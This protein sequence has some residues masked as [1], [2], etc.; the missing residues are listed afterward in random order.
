[1]RPL[2][3]EVQGFT[4]FRDRQE[5]DL[6][7][8]GLFVIT[9]PT[10]SGKTS[11]LDAMIFALYGRVP[12]AGRH[13]M[14]DL[15][16]HGIA[17]ARVKLEFSVDDD[18]YRV[19]RRLSRSQAQ[20]A[21][22]ERVEGDQWRS[23]VDGSGVKV[24]DTRIV[25]L[26]R[27]PYDAFTRAVVLPQ[28]EFHQFL[29]GDRD[30]RRKILTRLLGLDHYEEMGRRARTRAKDLETK[31]E[32]TD[33]VLAE[34]Y[35]DV[36]EEAKGQLEVRAAE[37][38]RRATELT[39]ALKRAEGIEAEQGTLTSTVDKLGERS[40]QIDEITAKLSDEQAGYGEAQRRHEQLAKAQHEA[41]EAL[42]KC[43]DDVVAAETRLTEG[44]KKHGTLEK[45]TRLESTVET[46][47]DAERERS[48]R[49]VMLDTLRREQRDAANAAAIAK[50]EETRTAE[51]VSEAEKRETTCRDE[52]EGRKAETGLLIAGLREAESAFQEHG[53]AATNA[54]KAAKSLSTAAQKL[55]PA[56]K[57]LASAEESLR[58][59]RHRYEVAV[60]AAGLEPGDPCPVCER[61]LDQHPAVD[62][63]AEEALQEAEAKLQV[64]REAQQ[65]AE[66]ALATSQERDRTA[67]E[68]LTAAERRFAKALGDAGDVAAL[69]QE[70]TSAA[71]RA[72]AA[73][74]GLAAA[75][76]TLKE[77]REA[78]RKATATAVE[79]K[80]AVDACEDRA[81]LVKEAMATAERRRETAAKLLRAHF[82]KEVPDDAGQ[83][84]KAE[85]LVVEDAQ[86][87]LAD[88]QQKTS[89]ARD[90]RDDLAADLA[91]SQQ[92]LSAVDERIAGLRAHCEAVGA[93]LVAELNSLDGKLS[94]PVL[95]AQPGTRDKRV[96]QLQNWCDSG[97]AIIAK[98]LRA[99]EKAGEKLERQLDRLVAKHKVAVE[100]GRNPASILRETTEAAL[101]TRGKLR[102]QAQ[103]MA[104]RLGQRKE[105][106]ERTAAQ[107]EEVDV[108]NALSAELRANRF[109]GFILQE[110]LDLL[111][112]R[113]SDELM[114]ISD[115]RYSLVSEEGDFAVV[116]HIN[117]DERR[118]VNTLSGGETFLASLALALA[119]SQHVGDLAT[120]GMGAKLKAVFIDEGFGALDPE[121]LEDVIDALERLQE[122]ELM[123]GVITHVP[124]LA[125]RI[126][127]GLRIENDRG[128]STVEV[129]GAA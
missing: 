17:E 88:A 61:P 70:A 80:A 4:A 49:E 29:R 125:E 98:A 46:A 1:M 43:A 6:S 89:E 115:E 52:A 39:E 87:G 68:Q 122:S 121:T 55:E 107:R 58:E 12:R 106:E 123:V 118:G 13:G 81:R 27:L 75:S 79:A 99:A 97:S 45:L 126:K 85:R 7:E 95:E 110:T 69:R 84:L 48:E 72:E 18:R 116:D 60:V 53:T 94:V 21:T 10:G 38:E 67:K 30:E 31:V 26:L 20:S 40:G 42:K 128:Q 66:N 103:Q 37:A 23:A 111:A 129:A 25:E 50:S 104:K 22:L 92:E 19:S 74:K 109:V 93:Q 117:A 100:D 33:Q 83:R 120:E 127:A 105:L 114:R 34:Q 91:E 5:V 65:E 36:S 57:M 2:A 119:L 96:D 73:A 51:V 62:P 54:A 124:A 71:S 102:E 77:A 101:E 63:T 108:L 86:S 9:G 35:A 59:L 64:A 44:I 56:A 11:L 76:A 24:V 113:A 15:I 78:H 14:K 3:I 16:S 8:L 47:A 90:R 41:E 32:A 112:L 28:G 82:G